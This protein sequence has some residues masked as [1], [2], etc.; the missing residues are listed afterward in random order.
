M[1]TANYNNTPLSELI[2]KRPCGKDFDR[3]DYQEMR[4]TIFNTASEQARLVIL[5]HSRY[6]PFREMFPV[7][8][9][10]D[11]ML[12]LDGY[13]DVQ[14]IY[15]RGDDYTDGEDWYKGIIHLNSYE[16][17]AVEYPCR[18]ED[19]YKWAPAT[20]DFDSKKI[21]RHECELDIS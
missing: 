9:D 10:D 6:Y 13:V 18:T 4:D 3:S 15:S 19:F 12:L 1:R 14:H 11:R 16:C 8:K 17:R 20:C 2:R 21:D 7:G 5:P